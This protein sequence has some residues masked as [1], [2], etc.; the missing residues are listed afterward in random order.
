[1]SVTPNLGLTLMSASQAQ[2]E[3][4][5]NEA[6]IAFDAVFRSV[7]ISITNTPPGSPSLGDMYCCGSAP[8][9]AWS[10]QAYALT[11]YYNGWQFI[12][13]QLKQQIYST[14]ASAYYT[15]QGSGGG[16]WTAD[17]GS[18]PTVLTDLTDVNLVEGAGIDGYSLVWNNAT[19]K[20]I[21]SSVAASTLHALTDVTVTEGSGIDGFVLYWNNGATKWEAKAI[22]AQA[23]LSL[24]DVTVGSPSVGDVV[25]YK[26]SG[27]AGVHFIS[28]SSL[29]TVAALS[30]VGDVTYSGLT[31]GSFL[32][33][34]GAAWGP[35]SSVA[36]FTLS[37]M[38][39]GPG[40]MVGKA[41]QILVVNSLETALAYETSATLGFGPSFAGV[42]TQ[43]GAAY[44]LVLGDLS[45]LV[46]MT[47]ASSNTVTV[48]LNASVA[49]PIDAV[50]M[51]EQGGAGATTI[52]A[53]SGVTIN[54]FSNNLV[55]SGPYATGMLIKTATD[56]WTL[57]RSATAAGGSLSSLTDVNVT[58][59]V[60]INGYTLNWNNTASKWE[61]VAPIISNGPA[62]L[63]VNAQT[64]SYI[65]VL[66]DAGKLVQMN[67][68]S[69]AN[70]LT[71]PPNS[72]VAFPINTVIELE[73]IG[74]GVT[75]VVAGAGV[76]INTAD[77]LVFAARYQ[78]ATLIKTATDVW[79]LSFSA[80]PAGSVSLDALT[81]VTVTDGSVT[82]GYVLTWNGSAWVASAP[83]SGAYAPTVNPQTTSYT[84][85]LGDAFNIVTMTDSSAN[86]LTIP[87]H[88]SVAFAVGTTIDIIALGTG[89]TTL[90]Y[91]GVT[92]DK[93]VPDTLARY[94]VMTL[95]NI[96]TDLWVV[97]PHVQTLTQLGDV[98]VTEG[99]GIDGYTLNWNNGAGMW[100]AVAPVSAGGYAPT[101]NT[102]TSAYTLV[103]GDAMNTVVMNV[104]TTANNLTIPPH[105]SVAWVTGTRIK[106]VMEGTGITSILAGA[107]VTLYTQAPL[108][109]SRYSAVELLC[110]ATDVWIMS[111]ATQLLMQLGDVSVTDAVGEN[112]M[113][114]NFNS[115]TGKWSATAAVVN[116]SFNFS[117][118][119]DT[120]IS[121]VADQQIARYLATSG[122]WTNVAQN[123][124]NA[125]T[126]T[127]YTLALTD[128]YGTVTMNN[129]GS[130]T[131]TIPANGTIPFPVGT[132]IEITQLGAGATTI[133]ITTDT[134]DYYGGNLTMAGQYASCLLIKV[135]AT[136]WVAMFSGA[137][138]LS[139]DSD[140]TITSAA[141]DDVLT[142]NG[143]KWVNQQ[144][145]TPITAQTTGYTFVIGDQ[146]TWVRYNSVSGG[147]YTI[148]PNSS[149]AFPVGTSIIM[150]QMNTGQ[151]TVAAGLGVTLEN[152]TA[153]LK[154]A[155]QYAVVAVTKVATDTWV[156]S[157]NSS[158]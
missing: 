41:G 68:T 16:Y 8:T 141:T 22:P 119:G 77:T 51:I 73:Q 48:P 125:Q 79:E 71:V 47:D 36:Y 40:S 126:G 60:G 154:T 129:V 139:L 65:L 52:A 81:D 116:S 143:S 24:S 150:D 88:A 14:G 1:M 144:P 155:A 29:T 57:V 25:A 101:V 123:A 10:G 59:G 54:E 90:V 87:A 137:N 127:S 107:G 78:R 46:L 114:L 50:I 151:L 145:L 97:R 84:L 110:I 13:P 20:W 85:V 63:G 122:K 99:V 2:K 113:T 128:A 148:P 118:L 95:E 74:T 53:T 3:V 75:T 32:Q 49:F 28:P 62:Y 117:G 86:N 140:V 130:N 34:N 39:D 80:I 102:Q 120:S 89:V 56:T 98:S 131:L 111:P 115:G 6:I 82:T 19:S 94:Q 124:V 30:Q 106:I 147:T 18:T 121:G 11:F 58:E 146:N 133:A 104:T 149:V 138:K 158:A 35:S 132:E 17:A 153:G 61:A 157:G 38:A 23:F 45:K 33:W 134:L 93:T 109:M 142:W 103:L 9:G 7:V 31:T 96:A 76:T 37:Q 43:S 67:L 72:S 27:G 100:K 66:S 55:L 152:A 135:A 112:G 44:T 156:F 70:N 4:V 105:A 15:F 64:A 83:G 5:F 26:T 91:T 12:T 21:A 136:V 69:T 42:N 92:V 108:A